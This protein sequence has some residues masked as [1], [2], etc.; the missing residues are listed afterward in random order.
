M[1][2]DRYHVEIFCPAAMSRSD[3]SGHGNCSKVYVPGLLEDFSYRQQA[4]DEDSIILLL[5]INTIV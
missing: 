4:L 3:D 2:A 1:R 5:L